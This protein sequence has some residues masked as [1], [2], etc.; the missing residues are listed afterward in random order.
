MLSLSVLKWWGRDKTVPISQMT[1]RFFSGNCCILIDE[2]SLKYVPNGLT[3]NRWQWSWPHL[4]T[5]THTH[6]T[7]TSWPWWVTEIWQRDPWIYLMI[8]PSAC[9]VTMKDMGKYITWNHKHLLLSP[10]Q[11][12]IKLEQLERLRSEDTPR[13]PMITPYYWPVHFVPKSI[14]LTS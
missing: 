4:L 3:S 5:H 7:H 2:I 1:F 14:L 6:N 9:E 12:K 13:R 10:K 8:A 11:N